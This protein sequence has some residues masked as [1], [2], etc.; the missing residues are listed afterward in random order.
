MFLEK[1]G[2]PTSI[3]PEGVKHSVTPGETRRP[4]KSTK[5]PNPEGVEPN[6]HHALG[7]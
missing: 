3:K 2:P 7:G 4:G 6:N 1:H 5:A